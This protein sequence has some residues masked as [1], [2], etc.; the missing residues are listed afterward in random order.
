[1]TLLHGM[2]S[3]S[4]DWTARQP[5]RSLGGSDDEAA[6][7]NRCRQE[8][9]RAGGPAERDLA[10]NH[11]NH[12]DDRDI[13]LVV[14]A[15]PADVSELVGWQPDLLPPPERR[16]ARQMS[17]GMTDEQ[18]VAHYRDR[19]F[20]PYMSMATAKALHRLHWQSG[21]SPSRPR[22]RCA[23]DPAPAAPLPV[24]VHRLTNP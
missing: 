24:L 22:R 9:L 15:G 14:A 7:T 3:P 13:D 17:A 1:M 20:N 10:M 18:I 23:P 11:P 4:S 16:R 2:S 6:S 19:D 21:A 5:Q 12:A 8:R